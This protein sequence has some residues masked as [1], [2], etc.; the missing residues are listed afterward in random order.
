M[1]PGVSGTRSSF[2][3]L[4]VDTLQVQAFLRGELSH[5]REESG[6][7]NQNKTPIFYPI[8]SLVHGAK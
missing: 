8:L 2:T 1:G 5:R 4:T 6:S 3:P 7:M